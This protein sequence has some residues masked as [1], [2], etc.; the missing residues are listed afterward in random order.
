M[1]KSIVLM[2][3]ATLA[4]GTT[5]HA[6]QAV[7]MLGLENQQKSKNTGT[8]HT[9][10]VNFN[11]GFITSKVDTGEKEVSWRGGIGISANYRCMFDSNYG[12][13]L[14]YNHSKTSYDMSNNSVDIKL[15]YIGPSFVMGGQLG[16]RWSAH[17]SFG[18]GVAHYS[19][20]YEK[21][22]YSVFVIKP[23]NYGVGIQSEAGFDYYLNKT[24]S[25]GLGITEDVYIFS[26]SDAQTKGQSNGFSRFALAVGLGV[27][28]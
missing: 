14:T 10:A 6:Q 9:L 20:H 28:L 15:D 18:I 25:I 8:H 13:G 7:Q 4:V 23:S 22:I 19:E 12:F 16:N 27:N 11:P 21:E 17:L 26:K 2:L 5:V 24:L 1:K 3:L